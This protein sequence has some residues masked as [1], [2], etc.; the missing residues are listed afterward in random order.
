MQF[1]STYFGQKSKECGI[2]DPCHPN[3]PS[4]VEIINFCAEPKSIGDCMANFDSS[5]QEIIK[6]LET[7]VFEEALGMNAEA[8]FYTL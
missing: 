2:C 6:L 4:S 5:P 1:I 8:K 3:I 7:L